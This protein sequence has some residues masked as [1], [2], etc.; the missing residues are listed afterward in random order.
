MSS[1]APSTFLA[2]HRSAALRRHLLEDH[3]LLGLDLIPEDARLF[4]D[5]NQ[6][7]C[8]LTA[9]AGGTTGKIELRRG[10]LGPDD[11]ERPP[12]AGLTADLIV[13]VDPLEH[14]I[15]DCGHREAKL[16]ARL[17]EH[18]RLGD[19]GW[20]CNLRGEFDLTLHKEYLRNRGHLRLVRGDQ[21]ERYR[22]DQPSGKAAAAS[23]KFLTEVVSARK[24]DHFERARVVSR[25]CSYLRKPRRLSFA[26][27]EPRHVV[28]NSCNYIVI[29]NDV[30]PLGERDALL[31]VLAV[32]NSDWLEWRFRLTSSTNHVG[33][34]E[35][36]SLP[37][38]LPADCSLVTAVAE[39][40]AGLCVAPDDTASSKALER[41][42]GEE[43]F[44][45]SA[46][47]PL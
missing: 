38:P 21:I 26:L 23:A 30:A 46:R 34:Y 8:I 42:V 33:N 43:V 6:P 35:I 11:F 22:S 36:S 18:P 3:G 1:I 28:A 37:V 20:I 17:H 47:A 31:F 40:A 4:V 25:Q 9:E 19:H 14:R 45:L 32:L 10:V 27:I 12:E 2:D 41:L 15:P 7:T 44:G 39:L 5:V 24:R 29:D 13:S 16:L